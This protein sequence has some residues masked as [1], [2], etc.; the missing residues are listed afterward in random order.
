MTDLC[1]V[2][3]VLALCHMTDQRGS[4]YFTSTIFREVMTPSLAS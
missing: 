3:I 1:L 2:G 4:G